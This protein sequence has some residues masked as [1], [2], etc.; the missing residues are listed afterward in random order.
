M[1][2]FSPCTLQWSWAL[3]IAFSWV[4]SRRTLNLRAR[5]QC[6][7]AVT[8]TSVKTPEI[9]RK[10]L[11]RKIR[12]THST[13]FVCRQEGRRWKNTF[14]VLGDTEMMLTSHILL[15]DLQC[16]TVGWTLPHHL[17][18]CHHLWVFFHP[19]ASVCSIHKA[20]SC[21]QKV[22]ENVS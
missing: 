10:C 17:C 4:Q 6:A 12:G 9:N 15:V 11:K 5:I 19:S 13:N 8:T 3:S 18:F 7:K 22:K 2:E 1:C 21:S 14:E 20:N 16:H